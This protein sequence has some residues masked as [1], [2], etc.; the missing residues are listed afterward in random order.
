MTQGSRDVIVNVQGTEYIVTRYDAITALKMKGELIALLAP[1]LGGIMG[2]GDGLSLLNDTS[3]DKA[4]SMGLAIFNV[5]PQL[6]IDK[7]TNLIIK[8]CESA[9]YAP[10]SKFVPGGYVKFNEAF[11]DDLIPA[12]E[13]AIEVVKLNFEKYVKDISQGMAT[14]PM[15]DTEA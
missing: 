14:S 6:D 9:R 10:G 7:A 5:I 12:Y 11:D 8:L 2:T 13:L 15:K 1:C 4:K 3:L